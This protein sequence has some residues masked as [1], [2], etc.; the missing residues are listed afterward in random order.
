MR[1]H[2]VV[3]KEN[4]GFR[5]LCGGGGCGS[6]RPTDVTCKRCQRLL[7]RPIVKQPGDLCKD[8]GVEV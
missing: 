4:G 3:M 2:F 1:K 8:K 6:T 5:F 7:R